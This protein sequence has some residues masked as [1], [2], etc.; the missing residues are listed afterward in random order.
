MRNTFWYFVSLHILCSL[1]WIMYT[2]L[3]IY[4]CICIYI[5]FVYSHTHNRKLMFGW[6]TISN[7]KIGV[8]L[9]H[10][11]SQPLHSP[12]KVSRTHR[13]HGAWDQRIRGNL[14]GNPLTDS[15]KTA[16][17]LKLL[18]IIYEHLT[19]LIGQL[20]FFNV[21]FMVPN[22]WV[23][24]ITPKWWWLITPQYGRLFPWG[25]RGGIPWDSH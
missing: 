23:S 10:A 14:T 6:T 16:S 12:A 24:F 3:Y 9:S 19:N 4:I 11:N 22:A 17:Q 13:D 2:Y 8:H 18:G 20:R 7:V 15:A 1:I 5:Y 21:Y 25:I